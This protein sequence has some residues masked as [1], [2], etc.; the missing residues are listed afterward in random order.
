MLD[1]LQLL[2]EGFLFKRK[3]VNDNC[4]NMFMDF[5]VYQEIK[6]KLCVTNSFSLL[7][8]YQRYDNSVELRG[9]LLHLID[10]KHIKKLGIPVYSMDFSLVKNIIKLF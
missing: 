10:E 3:Y 5:K 8:K 9:T 4:F 2:G 7:S 1:G 6:A